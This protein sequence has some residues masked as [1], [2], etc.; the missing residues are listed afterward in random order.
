[1]TTVQPHITDRHET[2]MAQRSKEGVI[3][4]TGKSPYRYRLSRPRLSQNA[5]TERWK[6]FD[7][8]RRSTS[9]CLGRNRLTQKFQR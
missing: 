7:G 3:K 8:E 2:C 1:M 6:V 5:F 9:L 4:G